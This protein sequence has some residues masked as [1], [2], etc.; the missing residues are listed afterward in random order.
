MK[1]LSGAMSRWK[2]WL[3]CSVSSAPKSGPS[4]PCS[5]GSVSVPGSLSASWRSVRPL[6][7]WI[8]M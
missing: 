4:M 3:W 7:S 5:Q 1:M 8:A 2:H 6:Y